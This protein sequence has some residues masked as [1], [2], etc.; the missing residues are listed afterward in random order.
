[1]NALTKLKQFY[2]E[3]HHLSLASDIENARKNR[4][5]NI[6]GVVIVLY[7][8]LFAPIFLYYSAYFLFVYILIIAALTALLL[9]AIDKQKHRKL[10]SYTLSFIAIVSLVLSGIHTGGL[11]PTNM[12][13]FLVLPLVLFYINTPKDA[14][15]FW[16]FLIGCLVGFIVLDEMSVTFPQLVPNR[17]T[18]LYS[19][20]SMTFIAI[21]IF[22]FFFEVNRLRSAIQAQERHDLIMG[23]MNSAKDGFIVL[24]SAKN[25]ID[26]NSFLLHILQTDRMN[27]LDQPLTKII[28][29]IDVNFVSN[30]DV[31]EHE[32][33][34]TR[35]GTH[36]FKAKHF[37]VGKGTGLIAIDTSKEKAAE[38]EKMFLQEQVIHSA[39]LASIGTLAAGVAHEINNPL[40]ILQGF[41]ELVKSNLES[42][43]QLS[44][45]L[46]R[47][48]SKKEKSIKRISEIVNGLRFYA[49]P[50]T[51]KIQKIVVD[52]VVKDTLA[53]CRSIFEK[54]NVQ[55]ETILNCS[56]SSVN[57]NI[58]KLQQVFMNLLTNAKDAIKSKGKEASGSIKIET[59]EENGLISI[60]VTDDGC[61]MTETTIKQIFDPFFTTKPPGTGTGL[62]LSICYKII[63]SFNGHITVDSTPGVGT[64]FRI[65]IPPA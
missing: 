7:C 17:E 16:I 30:H 24:D 13:G 45:D 21:S 15:F 48:F 19:T 62:G 34:M 33:F 5:L 32:F 64:T 60:K 57:V 22:S 61:G 47:I 37:P 4:L 10:L 31:G 65:M 26:I 42:K 46:S 55:I 53:F 59:I 25:I 54:D 23:F 35:Q 1:M 18:D 29:E 38:K 8:L 6:M 63:E 40:C 58:G 14:L 3:I 28:P 43:Q 52:N 12:I 36:S 27:V 41:I 39:K 9:F 56:S 44:E 20:F 51:D 2:G 49:R 50:D 11:T